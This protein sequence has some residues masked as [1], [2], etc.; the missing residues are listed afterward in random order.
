MHDPENYPINVSDTEGMKEKLLRIYQSKSKE[1]WIKEATTLNHSCSPN[2]VWSWVASDK[3]K[4]QKE[5][6]VCKDVEEG[7]EI[8]V[9]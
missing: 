4:R 3:T 2:A 5:V 1:F 9:S 8:L 6:R 7:E